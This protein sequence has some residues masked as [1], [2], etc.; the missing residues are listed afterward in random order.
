LS[1]PGVDYLLSDDLLGCVD[2]PTGA[3]RALAAVARELC[4]PVDSFVII[5][6][7]GTPRDTILYACGATR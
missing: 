6:P 1:Q 5:R 2:S 7:D 4:T 3:A